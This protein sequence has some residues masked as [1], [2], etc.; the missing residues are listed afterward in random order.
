M[1]VGCIVANVPHLIGLIG[2]AAMVVD[3]FV[4]KSV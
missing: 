2:M 4:A 1:T 3:A